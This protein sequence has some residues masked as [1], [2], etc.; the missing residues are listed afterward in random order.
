M[1]TVDDIALSE[2]DARRTKPFWRTPPRRLF[3][4]TLVP[5]ALG[6]LWSFSVP[7][8]MA[9]LSL[10]SQ[11][12]LGIACVVWIAW[13]AGYVLARR[14]RERTVTAR[15]FLVAPAAGVMVFALMYFNAPLRARW[16][17]SRASFA[18]ISRQALNEPSFSS[19]APQ[20]IGLYDVTIVHK[21]GAAVIFYEGNGS[22]SDDAG[23][24]YLPDGPFPELENSNFERPEF[25]HLGGPWY[26]WT[27]SW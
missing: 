13:L 1:P 23:F 22:L 12:M 4:G 8:V 5:P 14:K 16:H 17:L 20:R 6:L 24:A 9:D 19:N 26:A 2:T 18:S 7:G 27:A 25:R 21:R 11:A 3:H 10:A 15:W